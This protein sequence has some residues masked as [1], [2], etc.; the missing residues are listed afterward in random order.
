M[1]R[2]LVLVHGRS[3]ENKDSVALKAEWIDAFRKGLAKNG[4]Q[5]PIDE[6][7]IRFPYYG[8][9]L[10]DLVAE[11]PADEIAKIIVRGDGLGEAETQ[12]IR[13]MLLEIQQQNG[14][15]D[16][17]VEALAGGTVAEKGVLNW[18]WVQ[19]V[20]EALDT[21]VPGAS[22]AS[23]ALAT[24]DVYQYLRNPG[25]Q[26][27]IDSG[28]RSAF[29][30]GRETVV[31]G[32]SLGTIVSYSLLRREGQSLGWKVPLYVTLGSPLAVKVVKEALSPIK[33]P[34]C[35]GSWFNAMDDRDVVSL[36]PLDPK[37][38]S[39]DPPIEN[40]TDVD[41][42]TANRHGISGYLSDGT[43]ARRIHEALTK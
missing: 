1:T 26:N 41:N 11:K 30:A 21:Y 22:S 35:V 8:D 16:A 28:I 32:H 31:V 10:Y 34:Q 14:I 7:D 4:L 38:F 36:Y 27:V 23:V 18:R 13:A 2:Q 9:T 33:H 6:T 12:F 5:L 24:R 29:T 43:V 3:Q 17:Q 39:V 42:P 25:F 37:H 40:K 19:K 20:L 15:T